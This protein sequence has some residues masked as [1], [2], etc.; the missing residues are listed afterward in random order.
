MTQAEIKPKD[1]GKN[2][3]WI[4]VAVTI[5]NAVL[6]LFVF[7]L[8]GKEL[9]GDELHYNQLAVNLINHSAFS[10]ETEPPFEPTIYRTPGY[11]IF[12]AG[13]YL[14]SGN[15]VLFVKLF[16]FLLFGVNAYLLYKL[17]KF[18]TDEK[19]ARVAAYFFLI[20]IP[21]IFITAF[22]ITET[23]TV[24]LLLGLFL[25]IKK[26]NWQGDKRIWLDL[27]IGV[28]MGILAMVRP[29]TS[30]IVIPLVLSVWLPYFFKRSTLNFQ[31][32][33]L[34]SFLFGCGLLLVFAPWVARNYSITKRFVPFTVMTS[35]ES[36]YVSLLQYNG[37]I[38]YAFTVP[39]WKEIYLAGLSERR[40]KAD[41][42]ISK[43]EVEPNLANMP[44]SVQR[45]LLI[46]ESYKN[47]AKEEFKELSLSKVAK[48]LP[49][50]LAYLWS[51]ANAFAPNV[52]IH[53]IAQVQFGIFFLL[54]LIGILYN[55]RNLLSHWLLLLFPI[56]LTVMHSI[57][58]E[59]PRYTIPARPFILIYCA[60]AAVWLWNLIRKKSS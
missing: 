52:I 59:E 30:L 35:P 5:L 19:T 48:S 42:R 38:S 29:T 55:W 23:V 40:S 43:G 37:K 50:R 15:S 34:K 3:V 25:L 16:Q 27:I 7:D 41:E 44:K 60:I 4:I 18:Y 58:H 36:S 46:E 6:A 53:R 2:L 26:Y 10:F 47:S 12:V 57:F 14:I 32:V 13:L 33:F 39:E 54:A 24:T 8:A 56:Y 20:Y 28:V 1:Q 31:Q 9:T 11:S 22:M 51:T 17:A 21:F 45:E 49:V